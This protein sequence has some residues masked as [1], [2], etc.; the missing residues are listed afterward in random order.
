MRSTTITSYVIT[1]AHL[2]SAAFVWPSKYDYLEDLYSLQAGFIRHG[3]I[4]NVNPCSF[5]TGV[6]GRQDAA[7]WV[8]TA[9]HDAATHDAAAGTG[10]LDASI[11]FET[12]RA[13]NPGTAFNDTFGF[14]AAHYNGDVSFADLIALGLVTATTSCGGPKVPFRMGRIDATEAGVL[15]VPEPQQDLDKH[16]AIFA[17]AGFNTEDM[18][19]MVACGHTLGGVHHEDFPDMNE[20]ANK[21]ETSRFEGNDNEHP[22]QFDNAIATQY[23]DGSTENPLVVGH[24]DTTNSDKRI[25]GADGNKTMNALKDPAQFKTM[26]AD[27]F[28]RM[29]DSV[30]A[31]VELTEPLESFDMK[32]YITTLALN[33]NGT[34]D[35]AG[36]IRVRVTEGV[37]DRDPE[38]LAVRL[39]YTSRDGATNGTIETQPERLRGGT[40]TGLFN[41]L[42]KWFSFETQLDASTGIRGFTIELTKPSTGA[43]TVF[44]NEGTG[45]YPVQDAILYQKSQSCMDT[46][47]PTN[48]FPFTVTAAVRKDQAEGAKAAME[49]AFR[50]PRQGIVINKLEKKMFALERSDKKT[51]SDEYVLYEVQM[52][53]ATSSWSTTMDLVLGEGEGEKR[54]THLLTNELAGVACKPL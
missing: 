9:Y 53:L 21:G 38:D 27:I 18:I 22:Y 19:A 17:K 28:A 4:D 6:K 52:P 31:G 13:E 41:E 2:A 42:F 39:A 54:V 46:T 32:P 3:F 48:P 20:N 1:G 35:F 44:D 12:D 47:T 37:T 29:I 10:G 43:A 51:P 5:N 40:S 11:L 24:N 33:S 26:C 8:R 49:L 36:R 25:F 30:P 50:T 45:F 14:F 7:A 34:L 23:L 15:G 16:K